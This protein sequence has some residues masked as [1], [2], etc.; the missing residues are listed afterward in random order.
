MI[1]QKRDWMLAAG[2]GLRLAA[3]DGA[4]GEVM[5]ARPMRGRTG[6]GWG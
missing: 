3:G 6:G 5:G 4:G 2:L 1:A